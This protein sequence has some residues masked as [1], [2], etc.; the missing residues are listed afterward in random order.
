MLTLSIDGHLVEVIPGQTILEAAATASI[1]IPT[2]C[3]HPD[4]SA[5]GTCRLCL[6]QVDGWLHELPACTTKAEAGMV[7]HTATDAV[8]RSRKFVLQSLLLHYTDETAGQPAVE[9]EFM[10]WVR[11]YGVGYADGVARPRYSEDSDP[12]PLIRVN[13]NQCIMCTRCVRACDEIQGCF[14]WKLSARGVETKL[15]AGVGQTMLDAGCESCGACAAYCPTGALRDRSLLE[16]DRTPRQASD[17]FVRTTCAYCGVGCQFDLNVRNDRIVAVTTSAAD[18]LNGLSLCVKGRYGNDFVHHPDRLT[19]PRVRQYLLV[20]RSG[21]RPQDRGPWIDVDWSTAVEI[22]S[23]KLSEIKRESGADALGFLASAKCTSEENYLVQKLA[24]QVVG[25]NNI[26][27]CARL[28]HASTVTGLSMAYGSGAMSNSMDD[29][30]ANAQALFVIGS[31]TTEQH[32]VF[33]AMLRQAVIARQVKL[34]VADPRRVGLSDFAT[35]YLRHRPG[36]DV[37][38]VNGIMHIVLENGWQ[39]QAFIDNRCDGFDDFRTTLA[40]YTPARVAEISGVPEAQLYSAA[41]ILA[42]NHPMAVIWAMGIT[43]HTTGVFNVLSLANL[44]MLL[45]NMGIAGGGV[46]PLRGQ[47]NVQGACDMGALPNVLS[48]YQSVTDPVVQAKFSTA[49]AVEKHNGASWHLPSRPGL[50]VTEMVEAAGQ[51]SIRGLYVLGENPLATDPDS[52]HVRRCFEAAEFV[53]LQELFASDTS[54]YADVLLPGASFAEKAGTFTNTDRRIQLIRSAV[55]SPGE[56]RPDW[57]TISDLARHMLAHQEAQPV[58]H[59]AG[60]DYRDAAAIM[61]EIASLTPSYAGVHHERLEHGERLQWPVIHDEHP[62]TPILHVGHFTRGRGLFHAVDH[63]PPA[64]LPNQDYPLVLT[65]GRVLYHWHAG[66][67]TRRVPALLRLHPQSLVEISADER[68]KLGLTDGQMVRVTTRRGQMLARAFVTD[69]VPSGVIFGTFHFP[70]EQNVNNLTNAALDP[71]AK[72]PEYK[73]CAAR[74]E[75]SVPS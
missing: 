5:V 26:D 18:T 2:L 9:S 38:L 67:M 17:R 37:A 54:L 33:G 65:T 45:G 15:V 30:A 40:G 75:A 29:V 3:Y 13:L 27:H 11:H 12:H 53:V 10:R 60:W 52:N 59:C 28:C 49:W 74:L 69:R 70:G 23:R 6:V 73:V 34:V 42:T 20:E 14:V 72:I 71:T 36:T 62:G 46:N 31:N 51:G 50:T 57:Q 64:E 16:Q 19:K 39:D 63:L 32:P 4:L 7:I 24:R 68:E 61:D 58:G 1:V 22:A 47:N 41:K 66:E 55:S 25:T 43:Q 56:V 44:Q 48:G 8:V 35:I 21:P